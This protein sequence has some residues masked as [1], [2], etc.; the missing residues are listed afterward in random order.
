MVV[1]RGGGGGT[2]GSKSQPKLPNV[3]P[4]RPTSLLF[5]CSSDTVSA[6]KLYRPS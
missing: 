1:F 2:A 6:V 3:V 4:G 5:R